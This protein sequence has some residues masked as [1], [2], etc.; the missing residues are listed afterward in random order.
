MS[1]IA[2]DDLRLG[3]NHIR[4]MRRPVSVEGGNNA[5]ST[6][7]DWPT[8]LTVVSFVIASFIST[9]IFFAQKEA[10]LTQ[11]AILLGLCVGPILS[12]WRA[13]SGN[14]MI[15]GAAF[16]IAAG[17]PLL[18]T[19]F[20]SLSEYQGNNLNVALA[21]VFNFMLIGLFGASLAALELAGRDVFNRTLVLAGAVHALFLTGM[22]V[23]AIDYQ[24]IGRQ[25]PADI[26][27]NWWGEVSL[28]AAL[29][30]V[31]ARN[32]VLRGLMY[33]TALSFAFVVSSRGA[34]LAILVAI[35]IAES[36]TLIRWWWRVRSS[37]LA[38]GG[39]AMLLVAVPTILFGFPDAVKSGVDW[40]LNDVFLLDDSYRGVGTGF[41]SRS[42][43]WEA[44]FQLWMAHPVIGM[45][46]ANSGTIETAGGDYAI[47]NGY[48][49]LLAETGVVGFAGVAGAMLFSLRICWRNGW[50]KLLAVQIAYAV[51]LFQAPRAINTVFSALVFWT[52]I[53]YVIAA[54][55]NYR[56]RALRWAVGQAAER[57]PPIVL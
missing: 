21:R 5:K 57:G 16:V 45:G 36:S 33:G 12:I 35:T 4:S 47:H 10:T 39:V 54:D 51:F 55:F 48:L 2:R 49:M 9:L 11:Q 32:V 20:L 44:G 7:L 46:L 34:L 22:L 41:S 28:G 1:A 52:S 31:F 15:V 56:R 42:A 29:C 25:I 13:N 27:P 40:I 26:H 19:M 43:T 18:L 30:A 14:Q 23:A 8:S 24:Q 3:G 17:A 6:A 37:G 50:S 38:L 53:F